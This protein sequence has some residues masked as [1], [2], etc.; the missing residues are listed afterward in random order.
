MKKKQNRLKFFKNFSKILY[1]VRILKE[2]VLFR[3][4]TKKIYRDFILLIFIFSIAAISFHFGMTTALKRNDFIDCNFCVIDSNIL[5]D[6]T[7]FYSKKITHENK[8]DANT[9]E[10]ILLIEKEKIEN[11]TGKKIPIPKI[12]YTSKNDSSYGTYFLGKIYLNT[13]HN[14]WNEIFTLH[15]TI[16]HELMHHFLAYNCNIINKSIEESLAEFYSGVIHSKE[17][18]D[19]NPEYCL[20][21]NFTNKREFF[22]RCM[23]EN[24]KSLEFQKCMQIK[25]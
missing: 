6:G 1:F 11:F 8:F 2:E 21:D 25:K 4:Y 3:Y 5:S 22:L 16:R 23:L 19:K 9:P 13:F 15:A 7:N 12:K 20:F 10:E 14:D 17:F 18:C 24:C